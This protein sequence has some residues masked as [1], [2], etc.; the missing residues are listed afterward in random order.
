MAPN[1]NKVFLIGRLTRDPELRYTQS[2]QAVATLRLAVNR[3]YS[4]K[5]G[6]K[7]DDTCFVNIVVWGS[8]AERCAEYLK[9]GS[10]ILVEGRL[11][12]REWET[13]EGQK[14]S[15]LEVYGE[16]IQFIDRQ[17]S[18][19]QQGEIENGAEEEESQEEEIQGM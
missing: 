19:A 10:L 11:T 7:K 4:S 16:N 9:K 3:Q 5:D 6:T 2:T 13:M 15:S 8:V 12:Y 14:R 1:L 17:I 18:E